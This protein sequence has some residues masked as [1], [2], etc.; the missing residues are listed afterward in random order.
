MVK[1]KEKEKEKE[2]LYADP[3]VK[4]GS[5]K[6]GPVNLIIHKKCLYALKVIPKISIDKPKRIQHVKN[7]KAILHSLRK[8]EETKDPVDFVVRLEETFT[9]EENIN[10]VFEYLPGQDLFWI[11]EN[12]HNLKLGENM[13]RRDW[14]SFYSSEILIGMEQL[15]LRSIIYRDLKPDN[16]M[17]DKQG[18]IKI[19]DFGFAKK[20]TSQNKT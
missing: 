4:I 19:I 1:E 14:V 17:I 10:F 7:E 13:K 2:F 20:L 6:Y 5:G 3:G 8:D 11:L 12:E 18:H 9:D 16:V 15:H